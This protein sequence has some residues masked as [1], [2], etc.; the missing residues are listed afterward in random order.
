VRDAASS[1]L[2]LT[3]YNVI[4]EMEIALKASTLPCVAGKDHDSC[5]LAL[6][7]VRISE[8]I[9]ERLHRILISIGASRLLNPFGWISFPQGMMTHVVY[10]LQCERFYPCE[11]DLLAK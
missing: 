4:D 8:S 10:S 7:F 9:F 2:A 6:C 3:P 5:N 1:I 11:R